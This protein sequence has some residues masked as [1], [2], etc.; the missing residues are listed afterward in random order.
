MLTYV[1][2][3]TDKLFR[4]LTMK[5]TF[6]HLKRLNPHKSISQVDQYKIYC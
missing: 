2:K 1:L 6:L 5:T 4:N 3:P